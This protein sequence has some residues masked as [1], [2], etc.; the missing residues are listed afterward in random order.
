MKTEIPDNAL[1][2]LTALEAYVGILEKKGLTMLAFLT[3]EL[4]RLFKE[5]MVSRNRQGRGEGE[6][7]LGAL[8]EQ[9]QNKG[10]ISKLLGAE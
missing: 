6:R 8:R 7:M 10:V 1:I 5:N 4:C 9:L 2:P 3:K